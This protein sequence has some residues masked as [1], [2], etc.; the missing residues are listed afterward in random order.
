MQ[1][2]FIFVGVCLI[3]VATFALFLVVGLVGLYQ[4]ILYKMQAAV[5][6][7]VPNNKDLVNFRWVARRFS[8]LILDFECCCW[9]GTLE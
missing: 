9:Y 2:L 8:H 5:F 3:D 7:M 1:D 6:F 4:L